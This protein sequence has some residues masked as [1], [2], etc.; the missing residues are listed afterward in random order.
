MTYIE[1]VFI[2]LAIPMIISMFFLKGEAR[3]S[4]LFVV[5]GMLV[6]MIA[7][8]ISS[9]FVSYYNEDALTA[10]V[11]IAP[12]CEEVIK[13]LPLMF[14]LFIFEPPPSELPHA[15]ISMAVGFATF[16]NACYLTE[17]GAENFTFLLIRGLAAG[18]L[19]IL[20]GII[21]GFGLSYVFRRYWLAFTGTLGILGLCIVIH[22]IYN[23]L[24]TTSGACRIVGYVF[25]SILICLL[26]IAKKINIRPIF[27]PKN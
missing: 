17:N 4:T 25:P 5:T 9:F 8:Y 21:C 10:V 16:E 14:Y 26:L 6:C 22:A 3:K 18:A 11:E 1:N 7:A 24:V 15:A 23:L 19:H 13:L 2:C 27:D 20:C 12:V